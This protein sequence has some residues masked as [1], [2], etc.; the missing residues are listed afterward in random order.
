MILRPLN[1]D[2]K[3]EA[4]QAHAE[5]ALDDFSFLLGAFDENE[6]WKNYLERVSATSRG[7]DLS[8]GYVPATFLV[9]DV[10]GQIV[11][12]SSIRHELNDYLRERGG[13]IGYGVRPNFRKFG[14]ATE[15]LR[16][17][18]II[19]RGLGIESAL[20]TCDDDNIGSS[21]VIEKCGGVFENIVE[22]EDDVMLRR[23]WILT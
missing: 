16:Q 20:V 8:N 5:L 7:E 21:K 2:D 12:R 1:I 10:E 17:S 6:P 13:H 14:Y 9:A 23:Y 4:L 19:A 15:I 11:G 18:L 3:D 22:L